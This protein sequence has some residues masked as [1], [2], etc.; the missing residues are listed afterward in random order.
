MKFLRVTLFQLFIPE[1][2]YFYDPHKFFLWSCNL[3]SF[4]K[5]SITQKTRNWTFINYLPNNKAEQK[6]HNYYSWQTCHLRFLSRSNMTTK[7]L[8]KKC[9]YRFTFYFDDK[10][11]HKDVYLVSE[12][13][14]GFFFVWMEIRIFNVNFDVKKGD[15]HVFF[16]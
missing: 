4:I 1:D 9:H 15:W 3:C 2:S 14:I 8:I 5:K 11:S 13:V 16:T 12:K 10:K 7:T 6:T